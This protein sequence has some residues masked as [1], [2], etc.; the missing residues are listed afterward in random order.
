MP[1]NIDIQQLTTI[2]TY[3]I[4][5]LGAFLAALWLALIIWTFRDMRARSRDLFAAFLA[6]LVVA[7]LNLPG[8]L[9][10]L[11]LR[12]RETLA[13]RYDRSLEEEALLRQIEERSACPGCNRPTRESWLVCPHCSTLLKKPCENCRQPLELNWNVCPNC[14]AP[15]PGRAP[16]PTDKPNSAAAVTDVSM[17]TA[18]SE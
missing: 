15:A 16:R 3:V 12:P 7:L 6:A 9:I 11:L 17:P 4:S 13:E 18:T 14:A 10:Y 8:F 5:G 2:L 1:I